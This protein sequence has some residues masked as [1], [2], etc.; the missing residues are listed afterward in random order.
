MPVGDPCADQHAV[1]TPN[2]P[3]RTS[4]LPSAPPGY[5]MLGRLGSG[6]MGAVY[7]AREHAT[8]RTVA[9]KFLHAPARPW[10]L[11]RFLI[12]VRALAR[13]N[14]PNIVRVLA[15]DT[16]RSDPYFTMEYAAGG[17]LADRVSQSGPLPPD[18]AARLIAPV[19]R[20]VHAAHTAGIVHRDLKP[21]NILLEVADYGPE[22]ESPEHAAASSRSPLGSRSSL[23]AKISDFGLAKRLDRDDEL[24]QGS[25]ALGTPNFMPPEQTG[26]D[27]GEVGP[28][29]DVYALGATLY[30]VLTGRPPFTGDSHEVISKVQCEP[31]DRPRALRPDLP[32]DL[33]GI[34][35]KCL[36]KNPA[37]RYP[38]AEALAEDLDRFLAGQPPVAP[39]LSWRRRAWRAAVRQRRRVAAALAVA[40]LVVG[41]FTL[42]LFLAPVPRSPDEAV[43]AE[44]ERIRRELSAGRE[45]RVADG[46]AVPPYHHWRLGT[47]EFLPPSPREPLW[48]IDVRGSALL[49]LVPD[50]PVGRYRITAELRQTRASRDVIDPSSRVGVYLGHDAVADP[51]GVTTD[52]V[53]L[54]DYTEHPQDPGPRRP[55]GMG[56]FR[57]HGK[58]FVRPP[59][60]SMTS[61]DDLLGGRD[62]PAA[63]PEG[64]WRTITVEVTPDRVVVGWKDLP[65]APEVTVAALDRDRLSADRITLGASAAPRG[66]AVPDW[67]P[68]RPA[69]IYCNRSAVV[70]RNFLVTPLP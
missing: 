70:V 19:A 23:T 17:S 6:G 62:F 45:V 1:T 50:L 3:P 43:R 61:P 10:A 46:R 37:D 35:V 66:G 51:N 48:R 60:Q 47:G 68:R 49:E 57:V 52:T 18:E 56:P 27:R 65:G 36:E 15:V 7:L 25:G 24:T 40:L 12:E 34:V 8:E 4:D 9:M 55:A 53:L 16:Y 29:S 32:A 21:S 13:L 30:H 22:T 58:A 44:G 38:S 41:A 2:R 11:D 54:A 42:A 59:D 20:A 14:H 67:S 69:G 5:V 64:D 39:V 26:R 28:H 63:G 31:P 33:E